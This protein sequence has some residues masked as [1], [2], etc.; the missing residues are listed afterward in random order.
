MR[1][2]VREECMVIIVTLGAIARTMD[3]ASLRMASVYV[4]VGGS[5]L[6]ATLNVARTD[7]EA[8]VTK[9]AQNVYTATALVITKQEHV[10]VL[11]AGGDH[12]AIAPVSLDIGELVV[13]VSASVEIMENVT[14]RLV[15]ACVSLGGEAVT[16][17]SLAPQEPLVT[18]AFRSATA[19]TMLPAVAVMDSVNVKMA[20]WALD[21]RRRA[22]R[23][24]MVVSASKYAIVQQTIL[25]AIL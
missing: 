10:H 21:A 11:Q 12:V 20:G 19:V 1:L 5:V 3:P 2:A 4:N 22:L 15:N 14:Q 6:T 8:H 17:L 24:L 16:A 23:V 13:K 18:T 7:M 25:Y 9:I